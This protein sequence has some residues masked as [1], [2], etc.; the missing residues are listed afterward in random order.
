M[1]IGYRNVVKHKADAY[2]AA[3]TLV[4]FP[5]STVQLG[6][7]VYL[8]TGPR[9]WPL[10]DWFC[11]VGARIDAFMKTP[12]VWIPEYDDCGDPV[13]GTEDEE[14]DSYIRRLGFNPRKSIRMSEVAAVEEVT[15]LGLPKELL[16]SE[17]GGLDISA[18]CT[19]DEEKLPQEEV[20]WK[21]WDIAEDVLD[22]DEWITFPDEDERRD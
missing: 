22:W 18:W 13:W 12:K 11:V 21:S 10:D 1:I 8:S 19:D 7:L 9:D 15:Q 6:D 4:W 17:G 14:I 16:N 2:N 5:A 3:K 20:D